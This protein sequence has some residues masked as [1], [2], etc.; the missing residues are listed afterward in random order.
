VSLPDDSDDSGDDSDGS[1]GSDGSV[2]YDDG[3][4]HEDCSGYG[5]PPQEEEN[6]QSTTNQ[7][8]PRLS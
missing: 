5:L 4:D 2:C 7:V 1:D 6:V 3:F 8:S